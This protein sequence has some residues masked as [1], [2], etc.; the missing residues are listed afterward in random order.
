[1]IKAKIPH[2]KHYVGN[3]LSANSSMVRASRHGSSNG[4]SV[5]VTVQLQSGD[6]KYNSELEKKVE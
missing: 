2:I 4:Y 6:Q 1:M 5:S 3:D